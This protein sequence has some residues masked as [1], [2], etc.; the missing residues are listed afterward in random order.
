MSLEFRAGVNDPGRHE[1]E[2][3]KPFYR[4]HTAR[5]CHIRW[6]D[7]SLEAI[8]R[9]GGGSIPGEP[10]FPFTVAFAQK[11]VSHYAKLLDKYGDGYC[12]LEI[13][14]EPLPRWTSE[15]TEEN[16]VRAYNEE[17]NRQ[18]ALEDRVQAREDGLPKELGSGEDRD[19]EVLPTLEDAVQGDG[20]SRPEETDRGEREVDCKH[21]GEFLAVG[22]LTY[23]E[24]SLCEKCRT[25][26]VTDRGYGFDG[27]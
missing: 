4:R 1:I 16:F 6:M 12:G 15:V 21:D 19:A 24:K 9:E 13:I 2:I 10:V 17:K 27:E 22:N 18:D 8:A 7:V 20:S 5:E 3:V 26:T 25:W 11:R 23:P 14:N